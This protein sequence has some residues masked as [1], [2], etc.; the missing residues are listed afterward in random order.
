MMDT[1]KSHKKNP[2]SNPYLGD[3]SYHNTTIEDFKDGRGR[4]RF[5]IYTRWLLEGFE[6]NL[7]KHKIINRANDLYE[8]KLGKNKIFKSN[9]VKNNLI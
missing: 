7:T 1:L 6:N 5:G 9:K 4:Q 2:R 8:K 3:W